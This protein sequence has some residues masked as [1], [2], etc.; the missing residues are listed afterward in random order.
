MIHHLALSPVTP[1]A[2][3]LA[4]AWFDLITCEPFDQLTY[5]LSYAQGHVDQNLWTQ[6]QAVEFAQC[7]WLHA[8]PELLWRVI[9]CAGLAVGL[10]CAQYYGCLRRSTKSTK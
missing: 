2:V 4:L 1:L 10:L 7:A 6:A 9:E 8:L 5:A 3:G